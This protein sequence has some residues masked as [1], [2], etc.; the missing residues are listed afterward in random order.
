MSSTAQTPQQTAQPGTRWR[1]LA[2]IGLA[3]T[4]IAFGGAA[5]AAPLG[6]LPL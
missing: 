5:A 4:L 1:W 2:A 6:A 3:A